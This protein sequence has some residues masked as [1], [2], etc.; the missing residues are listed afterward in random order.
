MCDLN[1][2]RRYAWGAAGLMHMY[3]HRNDASISTSRQCW[4]YEHFSSV[5]ECNADPNYDEV[6]PRACRWIATK[7]T[8]KKISTV[9]YRQLGS[10][11]NSRCLLDAIWGALTGQLRWGPVA[12]RYRSEK[13]MR[14]FGYVQ[15]ILAHPVDS[16]VSFDDVDDRWTHYSDHLAPAG[17][18][19]VVSSQC[20]PDYID[21]FFIISHSFMTAPQT[22]DPPR[23]ASATQP[24]HIPQVP[25]SRVP[26]ESAVAASTHA[27]FDADEPRHAVISEVCHAIVETLEH[28][29]SL[30]EVT[31]GTST[32]KAIQKCLRIVRGVTEDRNV[33]V[34]SQRRWRTDQP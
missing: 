14:Q 22:S 2:T 29:L 32:H 6:S 21:R 26:Q 1:Q 27:D 18:I 24:R 25:E 17:D 7:K 28:H 12:V 4:I 5:A 33:Y 31:P 13:V 23:D 3:D 16:W 9:T 10:S 15:S 11:Q 30:N 19:C 20:A 8:V 34:R